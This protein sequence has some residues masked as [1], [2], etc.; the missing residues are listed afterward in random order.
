MVKLIIQSK[1]KFNYSLVSDEGKVYN[2]NIEFINID[3]IPMVGDNIYFSE[4]LLNNGQ[5]SYTFGPPTN[6]FNKI[7][8]NE[9]IMLDDN[10]T[11]KYLVR[12]YG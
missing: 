11:S 1:N 4:I 10:D 8:S 5:S 3:K 7:G 6:R 9:V 12:Y 2:F